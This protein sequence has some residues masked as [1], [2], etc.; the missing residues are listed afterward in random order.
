MDASRQWRLV[1]A[2][3]ATQA[4][5]IGGT[6]GGVAV[7]MPPM[8]AEF[9]A[10]RAALSW[11]VA[12][13]NVVMGLA[14]PLVGRALDRGS[15][16]ALMLAGAAASGASLLAIAA[17]PALWQVELL[18]GVGTAIGTAL[19]GPLASST[20]IAR[21]VPENAGRALG[22]ANM[23]APAG[24]VVAA[25][26]AGW[27]VA[28]HG[29]RPAFVA[30]GVATLVVGV[31]A[32]ALGIEAEERAADAPPSAPPG[33]PLDAAPDAAPDAQ[34]S[35]PAPSDGA[36]AYLRAPAFWSLVVPVAL[37]ASTGIALSFHLVGVALERGA[38]LAAATA[39][40]SLNAAAAIAGNAGF[41]FLSDRVAPHRLFAAAIA[42]QAA[43]CGV[44]AATGR[45]D[46]LVVATCVFGFASG[47]TMP[48]YASLITR[49]FGAAAFGRVMGAGALVG[50]PFTFVV[51]P[52]A[53]LAFDRT[54]SYAI[55]LASAA[56]VLALAGVAIATA[57]GRPRAEASAT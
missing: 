33:A 43:A 24:P 38:T 27:I 14:Y 47:G 57:L 52:L 54:G 31:L 21:R 48:L 2:S 22:L 37:V 15:P 44:L 5:A 20:L 25:P 28:T 40:V 8:E 32:V 16:R 56:A 41:G 51:P 23:G 53:G 18:F 29:W 45:Q 42:L 36:P 30:F 19:L 26:I 34:R 46:L 6:L 7:F 49:H 13:W 12:I 50:L 3:F 9:G 1:A 10:S 4:V 39:L 11:M 35:A 17:A 55:A